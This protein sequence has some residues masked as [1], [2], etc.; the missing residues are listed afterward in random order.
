M[1]DLTPL[2]ATKLQVILTEKGLVGYGLR[3]FVSGGG[4][5][6]LQYGMGFDQNARNGDQVFDCDGIHV[7]VDP[8]S[9]QYLEGVK[10]D[11]V[12]ELMGGGFKIDNPNAIS[13]CSCG[14][15]FRTEGERE[16]HSTCR[17]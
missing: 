2:A 15:S 7:Y 4:C 14:Q 1:V 10:I 12:D 11:Y 9:A 13:S 8:I 16:V 5:A 17:H 3:G 6:G